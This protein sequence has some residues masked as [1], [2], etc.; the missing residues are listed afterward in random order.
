MGP[1]L[2]VVAL[3]PLDR[4]VAPP[5]PIPGGGP[6][7]SE[8]PVPAGAPAAIWSATAWSIPLFFLNLF[9][10]CSNL[11]PRPSAAA[12][13]WVRPAAVKDPPWGWPCAGLGAM[14]VEAVET[15]EELAVALCC[16]NTLLACMC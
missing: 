14:A 16:V 4:P 7:V 5:G 9:L 8:L 6:P 13:A 10:N 2:L 1:P 11:L 15:A 3:G 12:G